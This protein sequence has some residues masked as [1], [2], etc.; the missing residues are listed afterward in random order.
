MASAGAY[1]VYSQQFISPSSAPVTLSIYILGAVVIGGTGTITGPIVGTLVVIALPEF[2]GGLAKYQGLVFGILL[3][4][5]VSGMPDGAAGVAIRIRT[6][7]AQWRRDRRR[8][9]TLTEPVRSVDAPTL[10]GVERTD[11]ALPLRVVGV[12]RSFGGVRAVHRVDLRVEPGEEHAVVGTNGS[13]KTTLLNLICGFY[14]AD[15]GEIW[16]GET[17]LDRHSV[18]WI[19]DKGVARTFQTPNWPSPNRH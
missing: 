6:R 16:L 10:V 18:S 13:G 3:I 11:S 12:S 9:S 1:Y 7:I 17:R 15:E 4:V 19:A 5:V 14:E 2:L 8:K